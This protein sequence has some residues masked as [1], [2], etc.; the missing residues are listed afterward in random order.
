MFLFTVHLSIA[1]SKLIDS[2]QR[3]LSTLATTHSSIPSSNSI[4]SVTA[5][6]LPRRGNGGVS[7]SS[8]TLSTTLART[9]NVSSQQQQQN[10]QRRD[11]DLRAM[12]ERKRDMYQRS[13]VMLRRPQV[14]GM[15]YLKNI[16]CG[17]LLNGVAVSSIVFRPNFR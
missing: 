11:D 8:A 5:K 13:T 3:A 10:Q 6:S 4:T 12:A 14:C 2:I 15:V 7:G 1:D 17:E 16:I 9:S